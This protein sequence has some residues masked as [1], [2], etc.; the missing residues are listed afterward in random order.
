[1]DMVLTEGW[2]CFLDGNIL[3]HEAA[4]KFLCGNIFK[5]FSKR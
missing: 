1:M 3:P 4:C 2:T 5:K